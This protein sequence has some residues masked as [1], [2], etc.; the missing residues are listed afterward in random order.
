MRISSKCGKVPKVLALYTNSFN[1]VFGEKTLAKSDRAFEWTDLTQ[2][3]P[4]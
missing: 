1:S 2:D 4:Q 3:D